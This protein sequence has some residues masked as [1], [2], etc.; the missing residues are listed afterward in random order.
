ML[1]NDT[2]VDS[3]ATFLRAVL[4]SGPSNGTLVLNAN[5]SFTYN[6]RNGFTGSDSF[7]YKA[8]NGFWSADSHRSVERLIRLL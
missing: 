5:G 3:P 2:D 6:P 8:D 7:T 1:A 4:V